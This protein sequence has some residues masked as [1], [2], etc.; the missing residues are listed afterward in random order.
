MR[1]PRNWK[2]TLAGIAVL[3]LTAT[4]IAENP[5]AAISEHTV[6]SIIQALV[7]IGLISA[8]DSKKRE[9]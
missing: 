8:A 7:G 9:E 1:R 3:L 2:T 5:R 6:Q 4:G